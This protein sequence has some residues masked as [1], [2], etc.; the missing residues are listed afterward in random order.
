MPKPTKLSDAWI[1]KYRDRIKGLPHDRQ[2]AYRQIVALSAE[3]QDIDLARPVSRFEPTKVR[4]KTVASETEI[5]TYKQ[6]LLCDEQGL[7]PAEL[8]R[9]GA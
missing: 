1:A 2:E 7:Y 4:E 3:P 8:G 5:P 6:H 9:F